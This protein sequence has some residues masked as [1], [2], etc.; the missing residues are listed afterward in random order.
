MY[1]YAFLIT[2]RECK[3]IIL[4]ERNTVQKRVYFARNRISNVCKNIAR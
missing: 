2:V 3:N 1:I 4:A